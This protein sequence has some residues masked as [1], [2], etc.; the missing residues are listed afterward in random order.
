MHC[1]APAHG[2]AVEADAGSGQSNG[3]AR[4]ATGDTVAKKGSEPALQPFLL[5]MVGVIG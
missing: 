2:V 3:G 5:T 1:A 4:T